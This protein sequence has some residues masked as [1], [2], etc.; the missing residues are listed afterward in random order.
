MRKKTHDQYIEEVLR[1]N[2]NIEVIHTYINARTPILHM[3]KKCGHKWNISPDNVLH[4]YGCPK[5]AGVM[6]HT[7]DNFIHALFNVNDRIN[8]IGE[9]INANTKIRCKCLIDDYEWDAIPRSLLNGHGCPLCAGNKKK[10]NDEY[11]NDVMTINQDIEVVGKYISADDAI[12]HRCKKDGFEWFAKPNNILSGKGCPKCRS[13]IG[14][15]FV[16]TYLK[17]NNI[18]FIEQHTFPNC[19]NIKLLPFDFYLPDFN[20]CI[21]YDGIQHFEPRDYFG[22][23]L[24]FEEIVKHDAIKSNYCLLHNIKLIRIRYNDD[25]CKVLDLHFN[26]TKLIKEVI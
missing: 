18:G 21:E 8:V 1:I 10:S 3:C 5:C 4:N 9:Y 22:G 6:K 19:K 20:T 14:E 7:T 12:L 2:P 25:I 17:N 24:A 23:Q 15:R 16:S 11:I 26:N 13:S